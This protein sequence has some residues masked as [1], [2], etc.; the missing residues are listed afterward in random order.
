MALAFGLSGSHQGEWNC[1]LDLLV[2][3]RCLGGGGGGMTWAEMPG[4]GG[5]VEGGGG[6]K[7]ETIPNTTLSPPE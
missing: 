4:D 3:P 2:T 6:G 1:S 7:R 5:S